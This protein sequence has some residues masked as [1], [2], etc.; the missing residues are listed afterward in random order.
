[1]VG[2][3][4]GSGGGKNFLLYSGHLDVCGHPAIWKTGSLIPFRGSWKAT[5]FMVGALRI[6]K[7]PSRPRSSPCNPFSES[8]VRLKGDIVFVAAADEEMLGHKGAGFLVRNKYVYGD[9]G[10]GTVPT[11]GNLIG[12]ASMG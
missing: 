5:K 4:K 7:A 6:I 9:M 8:N 2:V 10:I 12:I 3:L 1:V 11:G